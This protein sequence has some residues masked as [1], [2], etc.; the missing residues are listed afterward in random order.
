MIFFFNDAATTEIYTRSIVGSV[1]CVQETGINAEYM[2]SKMDNVMKV[3][4]ARDARQILL[5]GT[6]RVDLTMVATEP[7]FLEESGSRM[8]DGRWISE[9]DMNTSA[10]VCVVGRNVKRKLFGFEQENI[11]GRGLRMQNAVFNVI[12]VFEND[13]GT[14]LPVIGSP[15]DMIVVPRTTYVANFGFD[16]SYTREGRSTKILNLEYDLFIVKVYDTSYIDDTSKRIY[17][18][19]DKVHKDVKDWEIIVPLDLLRQQEQ[20]QNIFTVVMGSIAGRKKKKK[21]KKKKV[22]PARLFQKIDA[23]NKK[24]QKK[25]EDP[26]NYQKKKKSQS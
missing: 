7:G 20:T 9:V 25:K 5:R 13:L 6:R 21:K 16:Y 11:V 4:S 3:I 23:A 10:N 22:P 26:R 1:R 15:N 19:L 18:Y 12:G 2:G 24:K 14:Q 8:V 17:A